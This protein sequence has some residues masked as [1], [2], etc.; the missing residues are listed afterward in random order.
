MLYLIRR[1][2]EFNGQEIIPLKATISCLFQLACHIGFWILGHSRRGLRFTGQ[3]VAANRPLSLWAGRQLFLHL[4][5]ALIRQKSHASKADGQQACLASKIWGPV[6]QLVRTRL[7]TVLLQV[8]VLRG[9]PFFQ[10]FPR[11]ALQTL[12]FVA[13]LIL[14][15]PPSAGN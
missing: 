1:A 5:N 13:F 2:G 3:K 8:R 4:Q 7:I 9:P 6:V 14:F 15:F 11:V 10:S 12:N